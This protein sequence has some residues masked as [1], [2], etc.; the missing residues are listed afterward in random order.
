MAAFAS[1]PPLHHRWLRWPWPALGLWLSAGVAL[2][3]LVAQGAP[4]LPCVI[5]LSGLCAVMAWRASTPWRRGLA[6]AG[7]PA[8]VLASG[9]LGDVPAVGWLLPLGLLL[10]AYPLRSWSDAPIYPTPREALSALPGSLHLPTTARILDAGCGMGHGLR[11][12]HRLYPQARIEGV[13]WS[14]LW[15]TVARLCCPWAQV[16][17][18]D[19]WADDWSALD[20]VY[21]FQR[22][23]SMPRVWEKAQREMKRGATLVSLAFEVPGVPTDAL[24]ETVPGRAVHIYRMPGRPRSGLKSASSSAD[25]QNT[26]T[27]A[28][29]EGSPPSTATSQD[30]T[31]IPCS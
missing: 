15:S 29:C 3:L 20:V 5:G 16:R 18:G 9:M 8:S 31:P 25:M 4:A 14:P 24:F 6:A 28:P 19:L 21:V 26:K 22:P 11:A 12:W 7:F 17:R 13:E 30:R 23:E 10:L 2:R 27:S 1:S